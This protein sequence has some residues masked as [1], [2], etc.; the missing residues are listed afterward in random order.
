LAEFKN[1]FKEL[2]EKMGLYQKEIADRLGIDRSTVT[3]YETGKR[4]PD[5]NGLARIASF[6]GVSVDYLL[7]REE[8]KE[9]WAEVPTKDG[10]TALPTLDEEQTKNILRQS[11]GDLLGVV[12]LPVVG[13]IPAGMPV[14]AQENIETYAPFPREMV[15]LADFA[16]RVT[17]DSMTGEGIEEGDLVF[18]KQQAEPD[19]NGQIVAAMVNGGEAALKIFHRTESGAVILKSA[20]PSY[21]DIVV[22]NDET[23]RIVGVYAGTLKLPN[24]KPNR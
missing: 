4:M 15:G 3:A 21:H 24:R 8:P 5:P 11:F 14:L 23:F 1:R 2:R 22:E 9:R 12:Y 18:I 16:L 17:G 19:F 7:G 6:F 20:K 10:P 13:R